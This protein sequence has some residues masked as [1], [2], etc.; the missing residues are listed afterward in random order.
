MSLTQ[1]KA[2]AGAVALL[3]GY[4]ADAGIRLQ[5]YA[6]RPASLRPPTA[7]VDTVAET[8]DFN[9]PTLVYRTITV[10]VLVIHDVFDSKDAAAQK[11]AFVD[12][13]VEWCRTRYH[14]FDPNSVMGLISTSDLPAYTPDWLPPA[15]TVTYYATHLV[16][17]GEG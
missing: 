12:G 8:Y 4:A 6:G 9:G 5:W 16:L 1:A 2:R 13:F 14:E 11:D 15:E 17:R 3:S 7:F 10:D